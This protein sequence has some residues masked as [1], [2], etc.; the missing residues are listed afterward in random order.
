MLSITYLV[1]E[2]SLWKSSNGGSFEYPGSV[3]FFILSSLLHIFLFIFFCTK[4]SNVGTLPATGAFRI[5]GF[6]SVVGLL[7]SV[8]LFVSN[9]VLTLHYS[10]V[11]YRNYQLNVVNPV[12]L[13]NSHIWGCMWCPLTCL[14]GPTVFLHL[15]ILKLSALPETLRTSEYKFLAFHFIQSTFL[16]FILHN[17]ITLCIV[18]TASY[19]QGSFGVLVWFFAVVNGVHGSAAVFLSYNYYQQSQTER[20]FLSFFIHGDHSFTVDD[21]DPGTCNPKRFCESHHQLSVGPQN[22]SSEIPTDTMRSRRLSRA[23]T[24]E[25]WPTSMERIDES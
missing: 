1:I 15:C 25:Y 8:Q 22:V 21:I 6:C 13:S 18:V 24:E 20:C 16:L 14:A 11:I 7:S 23:E 3:L 10:Y 17:I 5:V 19:V 4:Y 12:T 2:L 9:A